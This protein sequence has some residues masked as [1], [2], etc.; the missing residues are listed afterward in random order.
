MVN[1]LIFYLMNDKVVLVFEVKILKNRVRFECFQK[2]FL[3][4][5]SFDFLFGLFDFDEGEEKFK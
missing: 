5:E 2:L 3:F 4:F 1:G